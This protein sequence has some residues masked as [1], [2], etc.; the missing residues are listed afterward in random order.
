MMDD[1]TLKKVK[2]V[3]RGPRFI[4]DLLPNNGRIV[5]ETTKNM[6]AREIVRCMQFADCYEGS[7][8]LTPENFMADPTEK[9]LED[10]KPAAPPSKPEGNDTDHTNSDDQSKQENVI[11]G[12]SA[13]QSTSTGKATITK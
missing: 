12:G 4:S 6:N 8:L 7:T 5:A 1:T 2:V 13:T 10:P 11:A 9:L 3:P